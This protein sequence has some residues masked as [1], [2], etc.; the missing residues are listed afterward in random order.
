MLNDWTTQP[1]KR[2]APLPGILL[3]EQISEFDDEVPGQ[4]W[5]GM[6]DG[7][8]AFVKIFFKYPWR[9]HSGQLF[10]QLSKEGRVLR[11]ARLSHVIALH[12]IY[13]HPLM[14][15]MVYE[16]FEN[17]GTLATA[18]ERGGSHLP[19]RRSTFQTSIYVFVVRFA[20]ALLKTSLIACPA[21]F[22]EATAIREIKT[23]SRAYSV[24]SCPSSSFQRLFTIPAISDLLNKHTN[25][26]LI[27]EIGTVGHTECVVNQV[28]NVEPENSSVVAVENKVWSGHGGEVRA[29][30]LPP[31]RPHS[32]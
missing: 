3:V 4:T 16:W 32:V 2:I 14:L 29:P 15:A 30:I 8:D 17:E 24:K 12:G 28:K 20:P 5:K 11:Q 31:Q 19:I 9:E 26:A 23:I 22:N 13:D 18:V 6:I 25:S 21:V 10:N 7:E 27:P 1:A